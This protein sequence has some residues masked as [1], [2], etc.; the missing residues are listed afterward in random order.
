[1]KTKLITNI[2]KRLFTFGC[3]FTK[4]HWMCWPEIIAHELKIPLFNYG[5]PGYGNQYIFNMLIQAN[6]YYKFNQDDLVIVCWT[7]VHRDDKYI[8][9]GWIYF[10]NLF[11][12]PDVNQKYCYPTGL[13]LRDLAIVAATDSVLAH[14]G[15]Q[16]HFT[17][18][19][20]LT[21]QYSQWSVD[22]FQEKEL[23]DKIRNLYEDLIDKILPSFY[24]VLWNND[25]T[26]KWNQE[27]ELFGGKFD[28]RHPHPQEHLDFLLKTFDFDFSENVKERVTA[29]QQNW[30]NLIKVQPKPEDRPI[31]TS[32][33]PRDIRDHL[34]EITTLY[35]EEENIFRI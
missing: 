25:L 10:G 34:T 30:Y 32:M 19:N 8:K 14:T 29:I 16:Y 7:N 15:C 17:S 23:A 13:L 20:D 12:H 3:S 28:D 31:Y 35:K 1:M 27:F 6:T 22:P 33:L 11:T 24:E 18:M 4:W 26:N 5:N 21:E 9:G 2:P